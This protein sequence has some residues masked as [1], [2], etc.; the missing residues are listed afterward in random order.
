MQPGLNGICNAVFFIVEFV[1]QQKTPN[2]IS[3]APAKL[4]RSIQGNTWLPCLAI[5]GQ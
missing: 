3:R 1:I 2:F 4:Y 5:L